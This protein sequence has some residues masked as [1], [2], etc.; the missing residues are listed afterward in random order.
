MR[1]LMVIVMLLIYGLC[2]V[3]GQYFLYSYKC[4]KAGGVVVTKGTTSYCENK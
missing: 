1:F 4:E 2:T 3:I